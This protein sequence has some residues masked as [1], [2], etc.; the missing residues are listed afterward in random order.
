MDELYLEEPGRLRLRES[1]RVG[2]LDAREA[3]VEIEYGGI[4]G[5]DVKVYS[6]NLP[7]ANYPCR[8]GHEILGSIIEAGPHSPFTIGTRVISFPNTYCGTC[9]F[10]L[11][12]KTNICPDKKIFGVTVNGLFGQEIV[13]DSEFI[14]PVPEELTSE[15]A[16]L[17][18]PF[19]V[20]VHALKKVTIAQGASVAV[21]GCGTEGF[22]AIAL[23]EYLGAEVSAID[24]NQAKMDKARRFYTS[25]NTFKPDQVKNHQ[26]DFVIEAA[27]TKAAIEM[28]FTLLK[29]G[30]TMITLGL[31]GDEVHFPSLMVTRSE[32][33]ILGSIIYTKEDFI[34]AFEIL[35]NPDFD[36]SPI[37]SDIIPLSQFEKA[38]ADASTGNHTKIVIDFKKSR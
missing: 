4:C 1:T 22:L 20:I 27:G 15:Q 35:K 30:G 25:I 10:C 7:Y 14:V 38:F 12:G 36:I 5:S 28:A 11:Q 17:T 16:I 21:V 23:L 31:T 18:E 6:G 34:E 2:K 13:V 26:F 32:L 19:A 29:P 9:E 37:L 8:P 24:I 3:R 33:S